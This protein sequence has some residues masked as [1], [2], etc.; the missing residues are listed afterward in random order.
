MRTRDILKQ[1]QAGVQPQVET[2]A[3]SVER[4]TQ[5]REKQ[6]LRVCAACNG[7]GTW[8]G[9][10]YSRPCFRCKGKGLLD[11][12]DIA[13]NE[14]YDAHRSNGTQK[15]FYHMHENATWN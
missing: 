14:R 10:K 9:H 2:A 8:H 4:V 7:T 15:F 5:P 13:R 6:R 11:I 12:A 3:P 1:L